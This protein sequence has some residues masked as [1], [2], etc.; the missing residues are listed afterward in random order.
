[1]KY[2]II[3]LVGFFLTCHLHAQ[4]PEKKSAEISI[5]HYGSLGSDRNFYFTESEKSTDYKAIRSNGSMVLSSKKYKGD[6]LIRL[7]RKDSSTDSGFRPVGSCTLPSSS[8]EVILF[9]QVE[10]GGDSF[11]FSAI[12]ADKK[13][14]PAGSRYIVNLTTATIKGEYYELKSGKKDPKGKHIIFGCKPNR[15]KLVKALNP[16]AKTNA[17]AQIYLSYSVN[18]SPW[19]TLSKS[20]WNHTPTQRHILVIFPANNSIFIKGITSITGPDTRDIPAN[21]L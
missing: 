11:K 13:I 5:V 16:S 12:P 17:E 18:K 20:M 21:R 1:M 4:S 15:K 8:K 6:R 3:T 9:A 19:K 2:L 10:K 14:F 7:F